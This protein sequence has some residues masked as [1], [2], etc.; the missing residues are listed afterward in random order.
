MKNEMWLLAF[1]IKQLSHGSGILGLQFEGRQRRAKTHKVDQKTW[2]ICKK[3]QT[4]LLIVNID[5]SPTQGS[6]ENV[7]DDSL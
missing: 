1:V 5:V 6:L 2:N 7:Q 3:E 4:L